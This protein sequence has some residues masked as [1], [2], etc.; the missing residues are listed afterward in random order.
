MLSL[1]LFVLSV[2]VGIVFGVSDGREPG[3][4]SLFLV[5]NS[6]SQ[7][8]MFGLPTL[9]VSAV[10]FRGQQL[11]YLK[12][13]MCGRRWLSALAG[14][15]VMMLLA[16]L[17]D[18]LT[19]WNDSWHWSGAWEAFEREL[20]RVGEESQAVMSRILENGNLPLNLLCV[21]LI[22]ALCEELFFRAGIQNLLQHWLSRSSSL[23][24]HQSPM[25]THVAVWVTA[26]I[27][28]LAHGEVFAFLPRF[29]L[30]ALLGYLY[31]YGRSL[32]VNVTA[33]FVNNAII[34]VAYALKSDGIILFDPSGSLEVPLLLTT[35]C[36]LA[37]LG[38]FYLAFLRQPTP[39]NRPVQ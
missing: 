8:M 31:V 33:H 39:N 29:L 37:A 28:S 9:I 1:A 21:A 17:S 10:Y 2:V 26:A 3:A 24:T 15:V 23:I 32:L 6:V 30:G 18:W 22:P 14:V 16:P 7:V 13:D 20:R 12:F 25:S 11:E 5:W 19:T 27:F 35:A 36:T 34:V 4:E 38:V